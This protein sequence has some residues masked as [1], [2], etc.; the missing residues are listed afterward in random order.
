MNKA[1]PQP[2]PGA[3]PDTMPGTIPGDLPDTQAVYDRQ[4][5]TFDTRRGRDLFEEGWLQ[6]FADLLP[7][8]GRVLDLGCGA[9]QPIAA[10]LIGQG[11]AV[12]GMDFSANMLDII[13]TRWPEGDWRL[14]DMRAL[15]L[16]ET[17]DGILGWN[18]FFH[19]TP[20]EQRNCLPRLADALAPDGALMLTVGPAEGAVAGRVGAEQV[21]HASL[22]S[23]EYAA[24]L[25]ANGLQLRA[26]VA[27][28]KCC[29]DH[30]VLL[31]RR[32][33]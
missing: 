7:S 27:E 20:E 12:T 19:L 14:G 9:G 1:A 24:L 30:S 31:A 22:S 26:F 10:W 11:F 17:F 6:R 13:R 28:D 3:L 5:Q 33:H 25:E 16:A 2:P 18:S 4:A 21:Y 29:N 32:L 23:G 8:G 15:D